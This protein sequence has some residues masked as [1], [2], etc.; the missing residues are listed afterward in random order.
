MS[1][2][3]VSTKLRLHK[4]LA[5][6]GKLMLAVTRVRLWAFSPGSGRV[7][8]PVNNMPGGKYDSS[9]TRVKPVFDALRTSG[10]DW[11]PQLLALRRA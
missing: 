1:D 3:L 6:I 2:W 4:V 8:L 11:L 10:R 5:G 9:K 7:R